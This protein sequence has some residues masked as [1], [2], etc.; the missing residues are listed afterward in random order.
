MSFQVVEIKNNT[1]GEITALETEYRGCVRSKDGS[2]HP[3]F[4]TPVS[5]L[6]AYNRAKEKAECEN[7]WRPGSYDLDDIIVE[8][9]TVAVT[10]KYAPWK[11][12]M[13]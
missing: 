3:K 12:S 10:K 6:L 1:T 5:A 7:Q 9:R 2:Y 13:L 11:V 4:T 8:E